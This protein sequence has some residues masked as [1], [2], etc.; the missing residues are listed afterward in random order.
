L[1]A[2]ATGF[3]NL[4]TAYYYEGRYREATAV[5]EKAVEQRP[6]DFVIWGNLGDAR[7]LTPELKDRAR[8]AWNSAA[9][10][11]RGHL[12]INPG[13]AQA[14]SSLAVYEAQ[15]DNRTAALADIARALHTLSSNAR[16]LS[17]AARVY[18]LC[19]RR[20]EAFEAL[21]AALQTGESPMTLRREPDLAALL[22]DPACVQFLP[23]EVCYESETNTRNSGQT[24]ASA[25]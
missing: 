7:R 6:S 14:R 10:L 15:M 20:R 4:G 13:D 3:S 17:K 2:T 24:R 19:G 11:A 16:V 23:K 21:K 1:K 5:L 9:A 12:T 8:Q 18:E 25:H 22:R